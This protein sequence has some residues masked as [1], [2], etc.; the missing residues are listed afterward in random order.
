M[1]DLK[2]IR[3]N[4]EIVKQGL[5]AKNKDKANYTGKDVDDLLALDLRRREILGEV[6]LLKAERNKASKLIGELKK[7][8]QN[9]DEQMKATGE[10]GDKIDSL[11][12]ELKGVESDIHEILIR[13]PNLPHS[14]VPVGTED[15]FVITKVAGQKPEFAF[16]A[17][18]H[19]ELGENLDIL[20]FKRSAKISGSGFPL[21]KGKGAQLERALLNYMLDFHQRKGFTEVIPPIMVTP[22]SMFGTGQLPKM[23]DDMYYCEGDD[24]YLIPTAEVSI[25][26]MHKDEILAL[27]DLPLNYDGYTPCFRREAGRYGKD[28]RGL[29]RMHQFNKV[30]MVKIVAPETSYAELENLVGSVEEILTELGI[31]YRLK[32]L[33]TEDLSFGAAK[34]YDIETWAPGEEEF[35]EASSCSNFED[36]QARRMNTKFRRASNEKAEFVHTLNGS[37]IATSRLLVSILETYQ[38]ADGSIT[39]PEVL[40]KY[41][42]F[43]KIEKV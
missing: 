28:T 41:T 37:G 13:F 6:E 27:A 7:S 10:I 35:L 32:L 12:K 38:N 23:K 40:R 3:E 29:R 9:A 2:F 1:L 31:H 8:G 25:T 17:Q 24:L 30:E 43:D 26:N 21:Y 34:C 11:D 14:S 42:G 20:D 19:Y 5:K 39:V 15:E 18:T 36:F 33:S 4:P 16:K 22:D